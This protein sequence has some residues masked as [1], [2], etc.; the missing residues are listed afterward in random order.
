MKVKFL[1]LLCMAVTFLYSCSFMNYRNNFCATFSR[2]E[3]IRD[4]RTI[5]PEMKVV[6]VVPSEFEGIYE[7]SYLKSEGPES[8]GLSEIGIFYYHPCRKILMFGEF[9]LSNGTF[10]TGERIKFYED[11][12]L[13]RSKIHEFEQK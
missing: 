11:Q 5:F 9:I 8:S 1:A 6:D 2:E 10:L 3:V 13:N 7:V 12:F 4:V